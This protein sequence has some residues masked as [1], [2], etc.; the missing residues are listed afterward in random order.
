MTARI[1]IALFDS[2]APLEP[3]FRGAATQLRGATEI[4]PFADF[5]ALD[6]AGLRALARDLANVGGR[7]DLLA[8]LRGRSPAPLFDDGL[9]EERG[10]ARS[11]QRK[12]A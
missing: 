11:Q 8:P 1:Y 3:A 12:R 9:P 5:V 7:P 6:E 4:M 2:P 10:P